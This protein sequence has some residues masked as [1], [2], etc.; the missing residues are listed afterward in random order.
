M[1]LVVHPPVEGSLR[2]AARVDDLFGVRGGISCSSNARIDV[3]AVRAGVAEQAVAG[4]VGAVF[5]RG[6]CQQGID[7][8]CGQAVLLAF[9]VDQGFD[10]A[11]VTRVLA[12]VTT[13]CSTCCIPG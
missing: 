9:R 8:Q 5:L 12:E 4:H 10:L 11:R 2:A 7:G 13:G 3:R 1:E 6:G